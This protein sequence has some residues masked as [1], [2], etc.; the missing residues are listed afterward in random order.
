MKRKLINTLKI[1][2]FIFAIS[3]INCSNPPNNTENNENNEN[4]D[5]KDE[6]DNITTNLPE[7][8]EAV[9]GMLTKE[10]YK[11]M[12]NKEVAD[13]T[14]KEFIEM[15][16]A[17]KGFE[18]SVVSQ[19]GDYCKKGIFR[20]LKRERATRET[21]GDTESGS[22]TIPDGQDG[23][24]IWEWTYKWEEKE[25]EE[26]YELTETGTERYLS[27]DYSQNGKLFFGEVLCLSFYEYQYLDETEWKEVAEGKATGNIE[28]MG[29]FAGSIEYIF[30]YYKE[31]QG[32][33]DTENDK[34]EGEIVIIS[35]KNRIKLSIE[36]WWDFL[37]LV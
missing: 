23:S 2:L 30:P 16:L 18:E 8:P 25:D 20:R 1:F 37:Y 14:L 3:F 15:F 11:D 27:F 26:I 19:R 7:L 36:D 34:Y 22:F 12:P 24:I 4:D 5:K 33:V 35:G 28:F 9:G 6:I 17:A 10:K 29:E 13:S 31:T 21:Q 32:S